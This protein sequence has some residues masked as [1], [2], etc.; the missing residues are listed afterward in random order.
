ML[1]FCGAGG[2]P[3]GIHEGRP[4]EKQVCYVTYAPGESAQPTD[5]SK[6]LFHQLSGLVAELVEEGLFDVDGDGVIGEV[7]VIPNP[8]RLLVKLRL[9]YGQGQP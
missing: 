9:V 5:A 8:G 2:R 7:D 4:S 1:L 6:V 3:Q